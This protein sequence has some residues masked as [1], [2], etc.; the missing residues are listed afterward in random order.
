MFE[1]AGLWRLS[2][3]NSCCYSPYGLDAFCCVVREPV[4]MNKDDSDNS[5]GFSPVEV[6]YSKCCVSRLKKH[7]T[8]RSTLLN[9]EVFSVTVSLDDLG[10]VLRS[11][12]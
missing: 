10:G 1:V 5:P 8:H 9:P 6:G 12:F 7:A 2:Y 4:A 3:G 11:F